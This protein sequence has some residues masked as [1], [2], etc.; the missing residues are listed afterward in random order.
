[1]EGWLV[2]KLWVVGCSWD[3]VGCGLALLVEDFLVEDTNNIITTTITR[4]ITG[5]M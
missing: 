2:G 4:I 3:V 1:M 5:I